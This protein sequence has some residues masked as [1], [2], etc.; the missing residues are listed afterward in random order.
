M[1]FPVI[2]FNPINIIIFSI[3]DQQEPQQKMATGQQAKKRK[4]KK[5]PSSSEDEEEELARAAVS[6]GLAHNPQIIHKSVVFF[7]P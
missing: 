5:T 7:K 1:N 6:I 4:L 3:L 2:N